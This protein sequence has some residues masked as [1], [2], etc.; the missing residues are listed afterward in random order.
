MAAVADPVLAALRARVSARLSPGMATA[1][2]TVSVITRD[3]RSRTVHVEHARG[4][5]AAPM[6]DAE[7]EAKFRSS[8]GAG[9][10][11]DAGRIEAV[12]SL[13]DARDV[14]PVLRLMGG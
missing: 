9:G 14:G 12:W 2:A 3:G 13:E 1:A 7:L 10:A 8:S 6:T 5:L 4:S 11:I